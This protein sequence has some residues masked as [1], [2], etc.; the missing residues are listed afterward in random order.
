MAKGGFSSCTVGSAWDRNTRAGVGFC[1]HCSHP[2]QFQRGGATRHPFGPPTHNNLAPITA[3]FKPPSFL[4][5]CSFQVS[6][7]SICISIAFR[8]HGPGPHCTNTDPKMVP[9][10][11]GLQSV[12]QTRDNRLIQRDGT[13]LS[14]TKH[15]V[16]PPGSK[17]TSFP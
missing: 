5:D 14:L 15:C 12:Y 16:D 10:P 11:R 6:S 2:Q 7:S 3:R 1:N 9:A 4:P 13:L 17:N 8:S